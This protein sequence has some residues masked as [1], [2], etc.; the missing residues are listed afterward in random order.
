MSV[1][2]EWTTSLTSLIDYWQ[3]GGAGWKALLQRALRLHQH[4][5][6]HMIEIHKTHHTIFKDLRNAQATFSPDP[7]EGVQMPMMHTCHCGHEF[8]TRRCLLAHQ[9]K[10]HQNF[11]AE[12]PFLTGATCQACGL[13]CWT[14]QRLQQH[15]AYIPA[16]GTPNPCFTILKQSSLA[17]TYERH[18]LPSQMRGLGSRCDA[19]RTF[20]PQL[21]LEPLTTKRLR[22]LLA[23]LEQEQTD[24]W[25]FDLPDDNEQAGPRLAD[26]LT[27]STTLLLRKQYQA[28][29]D[30]DTIALRAL[31]EQL[32]DRWLAILAE[33]PVDLHPWAE[34]VF[35]TWG[36]LGR[37]YA[38]RHHC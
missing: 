35:M 11:S 1:P 15:L 12:R 4:Q 9:R 24:Y 37:P 22:T 8:E 26:L 25:A 17:F 3:E 10:K 34:F 20:G 5:N 38:P 7:E 30:A 28:L 6:S 13:F 31:R 2:S 16:A 23:E 18:S 14:T 36:D 33:L 27:K 29:Y 21:D 19:L 32:G